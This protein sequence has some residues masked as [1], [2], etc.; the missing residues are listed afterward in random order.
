MTAARPASPADAHK[1]VRVDPELRIVEVGDLR[2]ATL[3]PPRFVFAP[4]IPRGHVTMLGGH[5]GTG[6]T[7]LSL[8]LVDCND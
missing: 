2:T 6:K 8:T 7:V 1:P 4:I 5:G 3:T